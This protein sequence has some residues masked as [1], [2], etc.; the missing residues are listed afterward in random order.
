MCKYWQS[1]LR[2]SSV[3]ATHT[4]LAVPPKSSSHNDKY[5]YQ[6]PATPPRSSSLSQRGH[7]LHDGRRIRGLILT[8][9]SLSIRRLDVALWRPHMMR[10]HQLGN[11]DL[12]LLP[13]LYR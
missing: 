3:V 11:E 1:L 4:Y 13:L 7:R 12:L 8:S 2:K 6:E 5:E 9:I 10:I